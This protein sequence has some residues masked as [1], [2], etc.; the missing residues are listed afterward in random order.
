MT[1][2]QKLTDEQ[3][4]EIDRQAGILSKAMIAEVMRVGGGPL[5]IV[6]A[7][8]NT[9]GNLYLMM[10]PPAH[11]R[12]GLRAAIEEGTARALDRADAQMDRAGFSRPN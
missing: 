4:A 2:E 1:N 7:I 12:A 5:A 6:G 11:Y 10:D 8:V 9:A 3:A